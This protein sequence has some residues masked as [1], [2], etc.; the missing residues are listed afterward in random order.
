M[1]I[2]LFSTDLSRLSSPM[3]FNAA[4]SCIALPAESL[5]DGI[6]SIAP[7]Q[8]FGEQVVTDNPPTSTQKKKSCVQVTSSIHAV[9]QILAEDEALNRKPTGLLQY[10]KK[11]SQTETSAYWAKEMQKSEE[12]QENV[13]YT[14]K[15]NQN[16]KQLRDR[17]VAAISK[18][19]TQGNNLGHS[20]GGRQGI[21]VSE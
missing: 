7:K 9:F 10:F 6:G 1:G 19:V 8:A 17:E 15:I 20:K 13:E 11:G 21:L 12:G 18:Q 4:I 3:P 16:K 2:G 5:Q 14:A